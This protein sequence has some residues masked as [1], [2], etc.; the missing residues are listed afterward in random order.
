MK[1]GITA[2]APVFTE[3]ILGSLSVPVEVYREHT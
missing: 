1:K 2:V 3:T